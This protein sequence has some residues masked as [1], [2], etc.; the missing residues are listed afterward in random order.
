MSSGAYSTPIVYQ[1][2]KFLICVMPN[3]FYIS[4]YVSDLQN[5]GTK[6]LVK[7]CEDQYDLMPF[8]NAGIK[9]IELYFLDG[10]FPSS[11][12]IEDW[13]EIVDDHFRKYPRLALA[14]HCRCGLGRSAV[15]V[16]IALMEFGVPPLN[17]V[18]LI[19]W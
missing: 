17:A 10:Q 14:V 8:N 6:T 16:A 9:V 5:C 11:V 15:L 18:Q 4:Q 13:L 12:V 7:A 1:N 19:R 3:P 2:I